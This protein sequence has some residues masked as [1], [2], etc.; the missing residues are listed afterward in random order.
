MVTDLRF[1]LRQLRKSP[2]IFGG[3]Q[4]S[5]VR[6]QTEATDRRSG[7]AEHSYLQLD[8]LTSRRTGLRRGR[9]AAASRCQKSAR[10][11]G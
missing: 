7:S 3:R 11:K 6:G 9:L 4:R 8:R 2:G 10:P 5:V 1:A